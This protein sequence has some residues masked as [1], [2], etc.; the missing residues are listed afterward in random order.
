MRLR[1]LVRCLLA[2][3]LV[4]LMP[5]VSLARDDRP[6]L[7]PPPKEVEWSARAPVNLKAGDVEIVIGDQADPPE[8]YAAE[9]LQKNVARRFGQK[10]P[11]VVES[12]D[13]AKRGVAVLLGRRESCR[14]LDR[15]CAQKKID[16]SAESP[17]HDG[18]VIE[19]LTVNDQTLVLVGGSN[20][21]GVIYGQD[22]LFE[23]LIG[24]GD[25]LRLTRA[26]IRDW[27]SVPWRGR[28]Q[29]HFLN[30][31]RT[32]ELD[33]YMT[34]RVNWIDLRSGIYAFEPGAE[35][36]K[37][38]MSKVVNEAH[39][40]GLIVYGV[41]NCGVPK[42]EYPAV[43]R[44]FGEFIEL[45]ADGLWISFDDKGPGEDPK[46]IVTD[47]LKLGRQHGITG[48]RIGI[49]PPKGSYQDI[50]TEFNRK[51]ASIPGM[52]RAHWFWTRWPSARFL[53]DAR[54]IGLKSKPAWWH[55][56][57]RLYTPHKY[58]EPISM[59]VGWYSPTYEA[60]ADGGEHV[61]AVMPWG[62]NAWSPYYVV[63]TMNWWGWSPEKHDWTA[64]R[65]RIY[66]IV[67]GPGQVE[68]A[69]AFDDTLVATRS[70]LEYSPSK[71]D[72][73]QAYCP[74]RLRRLEDRKKVL[75]NVEKMN[76]LL[77]K[78]QGG[79]P[80]ETM[81]DAELLGE[82]YLDRMASELQMFETAAR[83]PYPEYWWLPHQ[84]KVLAAVYDGD[85][86]RADKLIAGAR[87]RLLDE[88]GRVKRAG[89]HLRKVDAYVSWWTGMAKLNAKGWQD[90]IDERGAALTKR[91]ADYAYFVAV[92]DKMLAPAKNPP[93]DWG[94][95][96]WQVG[97][98]L[99]ATVLP[100]QREHWWGNWMGGL[101]GGTKPHAVVF[102]AGRK[103]QSMPGEFS[104]LEMP[105]AIPAGVR[106]DR[107]SM[108]LFIN[109]AHKDAIGLQT[110]VA[111][112]AGY[113]FLE[114]RWNDKLLWEADLGKPRENGEW[115]MIDL[116]EIPDDVSTL[117]LRLRVIDRK[118]LT[119]NH[120]IVVVSPAWLIERMEHPS[121][122]IRLDSDSVIGDVRH[123][124]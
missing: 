84:R 121:S 107:L 9:M 66:D 20:A 63:A 80:A 47:V 56:W 33:A 113:R 73:W 21:R 81:V 83:M 90:L 36:D 4:L 18:Y 94:S 3:S 123:A 55:N 95:G 12:Q 28:P 69:M 119:V 11:I 10:W 117:P 68:A 72:R 19:V 41:V 43:M 38:A 37:P 101:L 99:L 13:R 57:P 88:V 53:A 93:L 46:Q 14:D 2:S 74:V 39:R 86:G 118:M 22:T 82:H 61:D 27:P 31:M 1:F 60:M 85:P 79:A 98:R 16:L 120:T 89:G 25:G 97:N 49:C 78:L 30:Y 54:S 42:H 110:T 75:A 71:G 70:L 96:R 5:R 29:T 115:F 106:R 51:I 58:I 76:G 64:T 112:W 77:S 91:V 34:A 62:G 102:A 114:L 122:T 15:L 23:L 52:E 7:V 108:L 44:T 8:R 35:L 116:P 104:E 48:S 100:T 17:G 59:A 67:F 65:S 40:R 111:R 32:G 26:S 6:S 92:P 109:H 124:E 105:V 50:D 87:D 24:D 45:G 103:I